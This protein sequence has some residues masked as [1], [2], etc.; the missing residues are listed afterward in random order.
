MEPQNISEVQLDVDQN[1]VD[2]FN[3]PIFS[4]FKSARNI[5]DSGELLR[6][7]IKTMIAQKKAANRRSDWRKKGVHV[8][9]VIIFSAT[10]RCNLNFKGCYNQAQNRTREDNIC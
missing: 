4:T 3:K 8:P 2:M 5:V 7:A 1:T 10:K 6:C 9:P